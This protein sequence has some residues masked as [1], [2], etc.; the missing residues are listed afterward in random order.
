M[1]LLHCKLQATKSQITTKTTKTPRK[2]TPRK[3][4]K[5]Q[6]KHQT[7]TKEKMNTKTPR[8]PKHQGKEDQG[9]S[10]FLSSVFQNPGMEKTFPPKFHSQIFPIS[11]VKNQIKFHQTILH[12]WPPYDFYIDLPPA[13]LSHF[14]S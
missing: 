5:H 6:G 8:K 12:A 7:N 3:T 1:H 13:S 11:D 14:S 9:N 4:T 2:K 10:P